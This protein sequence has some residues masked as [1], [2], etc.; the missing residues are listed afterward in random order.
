M[1]FEKKIFSHMI[2]NFKLTGKSFKEMKRLKLE[3][4]QVA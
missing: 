3:A 1:A 4:Q 2:K